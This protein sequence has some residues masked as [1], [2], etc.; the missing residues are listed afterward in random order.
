MMKEL[1]ITP[2]LLIIRLISISKSLSQSLL[3]KPDGKSREWL[4][5]FGWTWVTSH[6]LERRGER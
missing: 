4:R 1:T 6:L 3:L 5:I 2:S